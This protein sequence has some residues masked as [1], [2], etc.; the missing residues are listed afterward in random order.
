M[1]ELT[2]FYTGQLE[3]DL[4]LLPRLY[5]FLQRLK[6]A[7]G[8]PPLLLDQG[9]SCAPHVWHCAA[10]GGR[11]TLVVLDG[12]GYHAANVA[13]FLAPAERLRLAN[14]LTVAM[15]DERT[16]WRYH[17]P[18]VQDDDII[19]S[20][21]P[22]PVHR[23]CIWLAPQ[24]VTQV[25]NRLLSLAPVQRGQVGE[26]QVDLRGEPTLRAHQVHTMPPGLPPDPTIAAAVELVEEEAHEAQRRADSTGS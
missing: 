2:L 20:A 7:V 10:T 3:G 19:I 14:T 18:P 12:M 25:A 8:A 16:S 13:G 9:H 22:A 21:M 4:A 1:N 6:Q 26:V 11:S 17:V 15:I 23:L 24:P 5:T